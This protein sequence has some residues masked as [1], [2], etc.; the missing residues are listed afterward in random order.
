M[1][2]NGR[3]ARKNGGFVRDIISLIVWLIAFYGIMQSGSCLDWQEKR[4]LW[5]RNFLMRADKNLN[6]THKLCGM[7]SMNKVGVLSIHVEEVFEHA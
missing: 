1:P 3:L 6:I 7:F 2:N 4:M 5:Q